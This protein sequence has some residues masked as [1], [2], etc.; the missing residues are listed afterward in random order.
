MC[1]WLI[2]TYHP[3]ITCTH[4]MHRYHPNERTQWWMGTWLIHTCVHDSS[5]H[6]YMTHPYI[7]SIHIMHIRG[8]N[9]TCDTDSSTQDMTRSCVHDSF[10][11]VYMWHWLIHA[12]HAPFK[13]SYMCHDSF[14]SEADICPN[15]IC[16]V[17]IY[18]LV[19]KCLC[20]RLTSRASM[21]GQGRT[22]E[23]NSART[24]KRD[25]ARE[26]EGT[27]AQE[28]AYARAHAKKREFV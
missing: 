21:R 15:L 28:H 1:T 11:H 26:R 8:H 24:R 7:S 12:R 9:D 23:E 27:R 10:I 14:I 2:H 4:I 6:V 16:H 3:Y 17:D 18:A 19:Y 22:R 25:R 5:I 20:P 13:Y